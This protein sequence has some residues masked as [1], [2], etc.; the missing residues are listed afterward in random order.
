MMKGILR[1]AATGIP[2]QKAMHKLTNGLFI[3]LKL[4][5]FLFSRIYNQ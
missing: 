3:I 1:Y 4:N 2:K 5:S